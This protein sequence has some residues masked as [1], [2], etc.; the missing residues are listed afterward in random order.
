M[1]D[2]SAQMFIYSLLGSFTLAGGLI[3]VYVRLT[4][5]LARDKV[6]IDELEKK[7]IRLEN[8]VDNHYEKFNE[9]FGEIKDDIH[10]VRLL[11]EQQ[12]P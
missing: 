4:N 11:I 9:M 1:I 3:A 2:I 8:Q 5:Q 10:A 7:V 6:R 12:K